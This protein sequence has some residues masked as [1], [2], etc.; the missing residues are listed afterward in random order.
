VGIPTQQEQPGF[1][2]DIKGGT[3]MFYRLLTLGT[4]ISLTACNGVHDPSSVSR[5]AEPALQASRPVELTVTLAQL[6]QRPTPTGLP[7]RFQISSARI[8]DAGQKTEI[9]WR[10]LDGDPQKAPRSGSGTLEL[11][12][13]RTIKI[14]LKAVDGA[15][16]PALVLEGT[17]DGMH[18]SGSF[19]DRLFYARGGSFV[20]EIQQK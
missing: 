17:L 10:T 1:Q 11:V 3:P 15:D 14:T 18:A 20:A 16:Q 2:Y 13:A 8:P 5:N 6:T 7:S 4:L 9:T 19:T 12:D